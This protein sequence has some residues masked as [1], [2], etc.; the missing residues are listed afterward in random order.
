[1]IYKS[2]FISAGHSLTDPG[3]ITAQIVDGRRVTRTEAEIVTEFRNLVSFYLT[4]DGVPHTI[5]GDTSKDN[6]PLQRA[7]RAAANHDLSLEFHTN[8]FHSPA[9]TGVETLSQTKDFAFGAK[10][11]AAISTILGITD[12]GAKEEGAGQHSRLAFVRSGGIIVELFFLSNPD[13]LAAFDAKKWLVAR[14]VARL[15]VEEAAVPPVR[16]ACGP[17]P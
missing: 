14:E 9:A 6:W 7:A 15:I 10:L 5:D 8:S 1:M 2:I 13:D 3:A 4:R 11:C 16:G 17:N 12:R